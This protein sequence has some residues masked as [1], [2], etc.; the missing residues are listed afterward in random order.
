MFPER[1]RRLVPPN[2]NLPAFAGGMSCAAL[3][4]RDAIRMLRVRKQ[5]ETATYQ[6]NGGLYKAKGA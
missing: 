1:L 5:K 3:T 4:A 2:R 6:K